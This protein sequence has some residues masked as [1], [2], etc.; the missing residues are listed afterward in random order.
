MMNILIRIFLFL[1]RK[2]V[3]WPLLAVTVVGLTAAH[4]LMSAKY[5]N[6]EKA[7]TW[8]FTLVLH[9]AILVAS[10]LVGVIY[11]KFIKSKLIEYSLK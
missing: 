11:K 3:K 5:A 6:S 1:R 9:S 8:E 7:P 2:W 10:I 4:L